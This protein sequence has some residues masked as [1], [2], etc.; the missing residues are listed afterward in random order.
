MNDIYLMSD[1]IEVKGMKF[2]REMLRNT[3][4]FPEFLHVFCMGSERTQLGNN[5][6]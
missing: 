1:S 3:L 2:V 4:K 5:V 6:Q